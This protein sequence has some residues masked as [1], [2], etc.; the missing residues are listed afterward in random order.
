MAKLAGYQSHIYNGGVLIAS[1][2]TIDLKTSGKQIDVSDHDS[3][4][5]EDY[6]LGLKNWS[7]DL[8]NVFVEGDASQNALFDAYVAATSLTIEIRPIVGSGKAKF[9]GSAFVTD[10]SL[11]MPNQD[12]QILKMTLKGA[13]A[14]TRSTQP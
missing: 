10:W 6:L 3:V 5:W 1:S 2:R 14:L 4:G 8:E 9:T 13:G 7:V 12:A 11:N